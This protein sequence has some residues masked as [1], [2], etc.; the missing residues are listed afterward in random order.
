MLP[1]LLHSIDQLQHLDVRLRHGDGRADVDVIAGS[2]KAMS[3]PIMKQRCQ[4]RASY[5]NNVSTEDRLAKRS[6]K[7]YRR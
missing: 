7:A 4:L 2:G 6:T 1:P 5:R 3:V